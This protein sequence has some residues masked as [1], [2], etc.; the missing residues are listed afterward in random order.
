MLQN[1]YFLA[2][3]DADTAENERI[4]PKIRQTLATTLRVAQGASS[5]E[6]M[7]CS[8]EGSGSSAQRFVQTWL[9][10]ITS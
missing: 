7:S 5:G 10:A 4:L 3:I 2:K 8:S 9:P 1:A 6:E